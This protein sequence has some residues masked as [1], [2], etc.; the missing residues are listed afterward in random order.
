MIEEDQRNA[1][2]ILPFIGGEE[3]STHPSHEPQRFIINLSD[4]SEEDSRREWPKLLEIVEK[5]VKPQRAK[6][7][8][9]V[10]RNKWWRYAEPQNALY[11]AI[12][13]MPHV[14]VT[15]AAAT[16]HHMMARI[17]TG[18]I[19][20]HKLCVFIFDRFSDLPRCSRECMKSGVVHLGRLLDQSTL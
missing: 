20:S 9:D 19:L 10:Y 15:G 8:R 4:L 17:P 14:L 16:M 12:G 3:V 18:G 2:R 11:E 5:K 1:Q 7:K 13:T 6:V